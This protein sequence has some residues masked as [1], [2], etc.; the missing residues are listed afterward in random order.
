VK[1]GLNES[2]ARVLS[3]AVYSTTLTDSSSIIDVMI[4]HHYNGSK[5]LSLMALT[6]VQ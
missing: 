5:L 4:S 2:S 3:T 6:A 1:A